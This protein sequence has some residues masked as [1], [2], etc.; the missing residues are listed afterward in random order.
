MPLLAEQTVRPNAERESVSSA[1]TRPRS[2]YTVAEKSRERLRVLHVLN[3]LDT[4][5]TEY[6]VLKL[7]SGLSGD[8]FEQ[9]ICALRGARAELAASTQLAGKVFEAGLDRDGAHFALAKLARIFR[10]WR[11]HIVHG[12][13]WGAIEAVAAAR[14]ARVPVA[15]HSEHGY[16]LDML[17]GL[18]LRR[19]IMRRAAYGMTDA[20]FSV[21]RELSVFHTRQAWCSPERIRTIYNGVD[22]TRFAPRPEQRLKFREQFGLP[23]TAFVIG[24]VGRLVPIKDHS[25]LLQAGSHLVRSGIDVHVVIAGAGPEKD[26]IQREAADL[27]KRARLLGGCDA[28]PDLLNAL[29]VFVLPSICEGMSNTILEAM[30]SA[31]PVVATRVGGNPELVEDGRTGW[32]FAARDAEDLSAKLERLAASADLRQEFGTAGRG[33]AL[34]EFSLEDMLRH[35]QD[36]YLSLAAR[37]GLRVTR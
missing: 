36:L 28:V 10:A 37:R 1:G 35:Y 24:T 15:I 22:T 4:G 27:G 13:N 17:A 33:R 21:T 3:H 25:T 23:E 5:G 32:L 29:D 19:R 14:L 7:M 26:R 16:E 30:A 11:P 20:V 8:I 2:P 6:G 18:P 34:A 12:R 9:R 31:L